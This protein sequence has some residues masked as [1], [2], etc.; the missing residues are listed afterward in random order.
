MA[1]ENLALLSIFYFEFC[2][3]EE[4]MLDMLIAMNSNNTH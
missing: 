3:S 2:K 4:L 1:F